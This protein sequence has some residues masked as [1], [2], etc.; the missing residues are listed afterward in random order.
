MYM[1]TFTETTR[2]GSRERTWIVSRS[3]YAV[4]LVTKFHNTRATTHPYKVYPLI[5]GKTHGAMPIFYYPAKHERV[6][7][8]V[9]VALSEADAN[10]WPQRGEEHRTLG[11]ENVA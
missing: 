5:G 4:L 6:T 8:A 10:G 7:H 2:P 3:G 9:N 1:L 11:L